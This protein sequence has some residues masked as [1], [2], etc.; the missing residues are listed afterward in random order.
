MLRNRTVVIADA[1]ARTRA[2]IRYTLSV[3]EQLSSVIETATAEETAAAVEYMNP[4]VVIADKAMIGEIGDTNAHIVVLGD[5][6]PG[7]VNKSSVVEGMAAS[8][9]AVVLP[10]AS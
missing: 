2:I 10:S 9:R 1:D 6:A 7:T 4:D 5:G 3:Y 8:V